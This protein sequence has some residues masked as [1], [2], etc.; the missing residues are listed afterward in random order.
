MVSYRKAL[1]KTGPISFYQEGLY[2]DKGKF[3]YYDCTGDFFNLA[4][5]EFELVPF[6]AKELEKSI[7]ALKPTR[8]IMEFE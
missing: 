6:D 7:T 1:I 5:H 4:E 3:A 2:C 8:V